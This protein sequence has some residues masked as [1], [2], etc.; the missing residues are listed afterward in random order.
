MD[1]FRYNLRLD[2]VRPNLDGLPET[3]LP[4][5]Y[6]FRW[7]K[8]GDAAHWLHIHRDADPF[9][10]ICPELFT[11][12]FGVDF[13]RLAERQVFLQ[14][15]IGRVIGT[16][17]AWPAEAV[18]GADCGR[19]FWLA[20]MRQFQGRGLGRA[21]LATICQRIRELGYA[22]ASVVTST[23]RLP[24]VSLYLSFGFEPETRTEADRN[25]WEKVFA[26]LQTRGPQREAASA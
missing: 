16:A 1:L 10:D 26:A 18:H 2:M 15:E 20:V 13:K 6:S 24:A 23:G 12:Q 5:G 7:F 21:L 3:K 11:R 14:D 17:T 25:V 22:R 8:P 4:Q 9:Y 19:V